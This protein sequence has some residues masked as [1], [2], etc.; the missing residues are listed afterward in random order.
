MA[1]DGDAGSWANTN[2]ATLL[3]N[4][5]AGLEG[6]PDKVLRNDGNAKA[7]LASAKQ[8]IEGEYFVPYS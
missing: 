8:I 2:S 7:A 4:M 5:R 1:K 3:D 6:S